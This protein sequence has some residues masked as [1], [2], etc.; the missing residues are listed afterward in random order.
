M[1]TLFPYQE[2]CLEVVQKIRDNG[3]K[4]ALIVMASGLGKTVTMAFDAKRWREQH[5]GRVLFLCHNNDILYQAKTTFQTVNGPDCR[6]GYFHGEEKALHRVD[7]LF[8]SFQTMESHEGIFRPDEFD[9]VIVDESHHSHAK[10]YRSTI[11][12]FKPKFLLGATATPDRLDEL[13]IREIFGP[14]VY[15]LPLEEAMHRSLVTPVDYRLLTDEIQIAQAVETANGRVS[16]AHLNRQIFI[17]KRDDEIGKIILKNTAEFD[18]PRV[19]VFCNSIKHCEHLSKFL[20]NSFAIHSCIPNKERAV[21]LEMF[22]QGIVGT[23]LTVNAFNEGIDI[24]Q[25]NVVVFLRSTVSHT[26][27]LQQLGR[28]LRRSEGKEKVIVLDFVANCERIR[29]IHSMWK[30][31]DDALVRGS[32]ENPR[33]TMPP[34]MLN[35]NSV[36]FRETVIPLLKLMERVRPLR[37]SEV[38]HLAK[39]YSPENPIPPEY[40]IAGSQDKYLWTCSVCEHKWK[41]TGNSRLH[42]SA[43][44]PGCAHQ[45]PTQ[46]NNLA[47]THPDLAREYSTRNEFP[48]TE[49]IAGTNRRL[50]WKCLVCSYEWQQRGNARIRGVGC[51]LCA[52]KVVTPERN[53]VTLFPDVAKEYSSKNPISVDQVPIG[54]GKVVIWDC[55]VCNHEWKS[56]LLNRTHGYSGGYLSKCPYCTGRVISEVSNLTIT[57]PELIEEY[58]PKNLLPPHQVKATTHKRLWWTCLVCGHE[59]QAPG[60]VRA[61]KG[62]GCPACV[63]RAP[64]ESN[65]ISSHPVLSAE[66]SPRNILPADQVV[67]GTS[68]KYWWCCSEGHEWEASPRVRAKGHGCLK[69]SRQSRAQKPLK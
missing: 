29:A 27:F 16:I 17:P 62:T 55:S 13:D 65:T 26:I 33:E 18:A 58:S 2:E 46:R 51:P 37:I 40:A 45:V 34:M 30:R 52:G 4:R 67:V 57:N 20:P 39:E 66:Y 56:R 47:V 35:V 10:T 32:D 61:I 15:F 50:W 9:Y 59:W 49:I 12:Y 60:R 38:E 28:G 22:R 44:C 64:N 19:I 21:K 41:A 53:L 36:E 63:N 11:E 1:Y 68:K 25:A 14:E 54:H 7:F 6:Y 48:A 23:I 43:G 42:G 69:C 24:P 3:A 8:A 31:F 5:R